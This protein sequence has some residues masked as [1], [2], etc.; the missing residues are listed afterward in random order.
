MLWLA[1]ILVGLA[2][3]AHADMLV[4][5]RTLR[6]Q[7]IVSA[8]DLILH[9]GP[10]VGLADPAL[11]VGQEARVTIYAGR[12]VRPGDVGPPAIIERNQI[13]PLVFESSVLHIQTEARALDR[14]GVGE[15]IRVLNLSSRSPV[16]GQV[17]ADGTVLVKGMK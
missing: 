10:D 15:T 13:V 5:A 17:Q 4:A 9:T 11:I 3:P 8:S 6:A 14:A 12:P 1:L 7:T 2:F 16:M